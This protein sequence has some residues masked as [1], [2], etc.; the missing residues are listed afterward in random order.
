MTI[1]DL[2]AAIRYR[3]SAVRL[4]KPPAFATRDSPLLPLGFHGDS[5][6]LT[7]VDFLIARCEAFVETG[8]NVGS[9]L[10]YTARK[11]PNIEC[12]SC[13]PD[14]VAFQI[15]QE[16]TSSYPNAHLYPT[17]SIVFLKRLVEEHEGFLDKRCLFWLDA[18]GYGFQWP[19][20]DEIAF[21][22]TRFS[23][24]YVLID[25]FKVP[26]LDCFGYE[27]YAGQSCCFS[28][29]KD[30]ISPNVKYR[31]YYPN[32]TERTSA[33]HELRGWGLLD[34]G[35]SE[36]LQLPPTLQGVIHTGKP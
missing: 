18:H 10:A 24:G 16:N 35:H 8:A 2:L 31:L 6:T 25:D 13:E 3:L 5:H 1:R 17:D 28:Y 4:R 11:Y 30:A 7:L 32:Y 26:D 23:K 19:L 20:R 22:T 27:R 9:T 12:Y 15:A 33:F 14:P 21:L 34:F 29:I 36:A